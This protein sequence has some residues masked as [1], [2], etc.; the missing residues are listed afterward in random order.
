MAEMNITP[1]RPGLTPQLWDKQFFAEYIRKNRFKKYMG[2][3]ESSMIQVKDSLTTKNGDTITF[4]AVRRLVGAGVTGNTVLEGNEEILDQRSMK[5]TV[6]PLRHAVA[7]S[8]WD[9]QKSVI[10][11]RDVAKTSLQNWSMEKLRGDIITALSSVGT[12]N[13]VT[14]PYATATA[15]QRN[16]WLASNADRVRFGAA[17]ANYSAGV[18]ATAL[19]TLDNTADRMTGALLS[20]CKRQAQTASPHIR[21]IMTNDTNDEEWFVA[22]MPSLVFRDFRNDPPV[23]TANLDGRPRETKW[24]DNPMFSGGDLVWDGMIV[25]EIPELPVLTGTGAAGI[26][27][28][29]S[30]LCGAQAIGAGWAQRSHTT[31]N[32]RDYGYFHGVGLQEIRGI[33]K[34]CFGRDAAVDTTTEVDQGIFSIFTAAVADV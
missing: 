21:P 27:T 22:F 6:A 23:I 30:F 15:T 13:G 32:V 34:L 28:A 19:T 2:T 18:M 11:L 16:L 14:I 20:L 10:E 24:M 7:V 1:A 29:A 31:T 9:E 26:D 3:T 8:E 17:A 25:R 33:G 12:V 5:L 4:A